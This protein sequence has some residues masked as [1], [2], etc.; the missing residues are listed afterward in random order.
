MVQFIPSCSWHSHLFPGG[1]DQIHGQLL[2]HCLSY[3]DLLSFPS[4]ALKEAFNPIFLSLLPCTKSVFHLHHSNWLDTLP[5]SE[6]RWAPTFSVWSFSV[7]AHF[8]GPVWLSH[9]V[10]F[11]L[12]HIFSLLWNKLAEGGEDCLTSFWYDFPCDFHGC[13]VK[14][15]NYN[16][17][18]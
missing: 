2:G 17:S 7:S 12:L 16:M 5:F 13:Q 1:K 6:G 14:S 3:Q 9:V 4:P 10:S 15:L 18:S 11:P 8:C